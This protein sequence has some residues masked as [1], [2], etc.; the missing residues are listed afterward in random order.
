MSRNRARGIAA[1][2][3]LAIGS[4]GATQA[5]S[6]P[7][8]DQ[9]QKPVTAQEPRAASRPTAVESNRKGG[10][11]GIKVN[12]YWTIEVKNPDGTVA[13][14]TEFENAIQ[15]TGMLALASLLA[16]NSAS[17]GL[18]IMLDG[19]TAQITSTVNPLESGLT[20]LKFVNN[21]Q[22]PCGLCIIAPSSSFIAVGSGEAISTGLSVSGPTFPSSGGI[23]TGLKGAARSRSQV[24]SRRQLAA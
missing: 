12:G 1:A 11:D 6:T 9:K 14:H 13:S 16:G 3:A 18:A 2:V 8:P 5:Q 23:A 17:G 21:S 24:A 7:V 4:M 19:A 15:P 10:S 22:T 20:T